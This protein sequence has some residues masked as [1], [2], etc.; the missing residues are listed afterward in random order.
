MQQFDF[1]SSWDDRAFNAIYSLVDL[2][3]DHTQFENFFNETLRAHDGSLSFVG[4]LVLAAC[5]MIDSDVRRQLPKFSEYCDATP[6]V[7]DVFKHSVSYAQQV[8]S[9][10]DLRY[11]E[12]EHS[13][14][15][16][17]HK[18]IA[19]LLFEAF[20][21]LDTPS[22]ITFKNEASEFTL[23]SDGRSLCVTFNLDGHRDGGAATLTT[24][25]L[26]MLNHQSG[27]DWT[28]K[29]YSN[30]VSERYCAGLEVLMNFKE[31]DTE[32]LLGR[33]IGFYTGFRSIGPLDIEFLPEYESPWHFVLNSLASQQGWLQL[34]INPS[35]GQYP[36]NWSDF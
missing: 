18:A 3:L 28:N 34:R 6:Q 15:G 4:D 32:D 25:F 10:F 21:E 35:Q 30:F 27:S 19:A 23:L 1:P 5:L 14:A 17:I 31:L 2:E 9:E 8:M 13:L 24:M 12:N 11:T 33:L 29:Q 7:W 16:S 26:Q 36:K 20:L 22:R